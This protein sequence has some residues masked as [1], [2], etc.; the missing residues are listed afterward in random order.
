ME[1]MNESKAYR[2]TLNIFTGPGAATAVATMLILSPANSF[3]LPADQMASSVAAAAVRFLGSDDF[4][5][6][7]QSSLVTDPAPAAEV[8]QLRG[9]FE[10]EGWT[11]VSYAEAPVATEETARLAL[12]TLP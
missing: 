1:S 9:L 8:R 3:A 11:V 5:D 2:V 7:Q 10:C 4:Y 12:P 6:T